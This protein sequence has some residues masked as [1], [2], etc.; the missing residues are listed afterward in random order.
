MP[1][2]TQTLSVELEPAVRNRLLEIADGIVDLGGDVDAEDKADFLRRLA[3][4][5]RV[6]DATG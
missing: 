4:G 1:D 5:G 3:D 6:P 2:R